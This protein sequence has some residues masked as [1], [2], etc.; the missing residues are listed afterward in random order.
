MKDEEEEE[1]E[2]VLLLLKRWGKMGEKEERS[3]GER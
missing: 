1:E 3:S 2:D